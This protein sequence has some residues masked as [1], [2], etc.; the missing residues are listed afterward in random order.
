[1]T[2]SVS[3]MTISVSL[4]CNLKTKPNQTKSQP[5]K[6]FIIHIP[7]VKPLIILSVR[8]SRKKGASFSCWTYF[9][10][11]VVHDILR[12]SHFIKHTKLFEND[13]NIQF[14]DNCI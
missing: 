11:V 10:I 12:S 3:I 8:N 5:T 4:Q 7:L 9:Q 6:Y 13:V 1:M 2:I 14:P